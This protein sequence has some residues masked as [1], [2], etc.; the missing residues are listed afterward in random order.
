MESSSSSTSGISLRPFK[1]SDADDFLSWAGD[2]KVT[3][4]LRWNTIT[5]REEALAHIQQVAIPHPW[6]RS[7]CLRDRSIGYVSVRPEAGDDRHRAHIGYAV[8][9]EHWGRGF[10]TAALEKAV[11]CVFESFPFLVRLEALVEEEN[12]G[13]RKVLEK[14]GFVREGFLR[15]YGFNKGEIRDMFM[16]RFLRND[17]IGTKK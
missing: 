6:R 7:I 15:K 3:R 14:V 4:Y 2:D 13:S 8:G 16:Y 12:L 17:Q 10:A 11:A 1:A 5:S 9:S